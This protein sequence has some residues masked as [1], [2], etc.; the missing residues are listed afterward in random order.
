LTSLL[1]GFVL[2]GAG[3][4]SPRKLVAQFTLK[5][6]AVF[7]IMFTA[8][9]VAAVGLWLFEASG[10][11]KPRRFYVPT[12]Y[13]GAFALG[14]L[15]IG[16]GFAIGGYCPG[17]SAA[18]LASGRLDALA[19]MAVMAAGIGFFAGV[20][21]KIYAFYVSGQGPKGQTLPDLLG[22]PSVIILVALIAVAAGH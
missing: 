7:K 10:L 19:F 12:M 8:V 5:D 21:E 4:D 18:G 3:F 22:L 14:G 17:T 13:F 9:I 11:I 15:L 20:F 2:E 1:F 6:F 16:A